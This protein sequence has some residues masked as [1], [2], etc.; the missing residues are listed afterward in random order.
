MYIKS[1]IL[2]WREKKLF[3]LLFCA[4]TIWTLVPAA[5]ISPH[6]AQRAFGAMIS[7]GE[8]LL[9]VGYT[10]PESSSDYQSVLVF[11]MEKR[12][13]EWVTRRSLRL[14]LIGHTPTL[15]SSTPMSHFLC[16]VLLRICVCALQTHRK[17][18][19]HSM[20]KVSIQPPQ[21]GQFHCI[22]FIFRSH[23]LQLFL[24]VSLFLPGDSV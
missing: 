13:S 17:L 10:I 16:T 23:T 20:S 22:C 11:S 18:L 2:F 14:V 19:C 3:Y 8:E 6:M 9:A 4:L 5:I 15:H 1:E 7:A 12:A 24:Y 21:V